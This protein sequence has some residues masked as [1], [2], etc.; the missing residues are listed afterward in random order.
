MGSLSRAAHRPTRPNFSTPSRPRSTAAFR[1]LK[2]C[3]CI[4]K[5]IQNGPAGDISFVRLGVLCQ[6]VR[7]PSHVD[8]VK[9]QPNMHGF[10][11]MSRTSRAELPI[12]TISHGEPGEY[13]A[14]HALMSRPNQSR[15]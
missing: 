15:R 3:E 12:R 4:S 1:L 14:A 11:G 6:L 7:G 13:I 10:R 2:V 9:R 5:Y 8:A